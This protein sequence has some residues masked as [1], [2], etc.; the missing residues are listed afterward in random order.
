[1]NRLREKA[2]D[3]KNDVKWN[4]AAAICAGRQPEGSRRADR[5]GGSGQTGKVDPYDDTYNSSERQ[6]P[7]CS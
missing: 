6:M 4:A 3:L 5:A 1:M 2:A 7:W